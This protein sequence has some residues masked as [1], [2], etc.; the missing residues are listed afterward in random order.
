ML[1]MAFVVDKAIFL[2]NDSTIRVLSES[3][4]AG[5]TTRIEQMSFQRINLSTDSG[6]P[7][8]GTHSLYRPID[9]LYPRR[10]VA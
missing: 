3:N 7:T 1:E 5:F 8:C 9:V 4:T 2:T 10:H 6:Q